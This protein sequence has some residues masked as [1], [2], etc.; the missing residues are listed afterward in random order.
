MRVINDA[1]VQQALL[2]GAPYDVTV[3]VT[4]AGGSAVV[5]DLDHIAENGISINPSGVSGNRLEIGSVIAATG[6][7][8]FFNHDG[9][10]DGIVFKGADISVQGSMDI[11]GVTK[12]FDIGHFVADKA[13]VDGVRIRV[14]CFDYMIKFDT[15]IPDAY[16]TTAATAGQLATACCVF[17][18]VTNAR[19]FS[20]AADIPNYDYPIPKNTVPRGQTYRQVLAWLA[21]I[22]G[23][24]A[25]ITNEGKLDLVWYNTASYAAGLDERF[26]GGTVAE[27]PVTLTGVR[28]INGGTPGVFAGSDGYM[29]DVADN[30]LLKDY[31]QSVVDAIWADVGAFSYYPAEFGLVHNVMATP[32]DVINW[33][34]ED[35]TTKPVAV[36]DVIYNLSA[37]TQIQ[38]K[39]LS[40]DEAGYAPQ[41]AFTPEQETQVKDAGR[42]KIGRIE[43][44]D[45]NVYFDLDSGEISTETSEERV[46]SSTVKAT[47]KALLSFKDGDLSLQIQK[48]GTDIGNT[49]IGIDGIYVRTDE[50]LAPSYPKPQNWDTWPLSTKKI[51]IFAQKVVA[52]LN[53]NNI[54]NNSLLIENKAPPAN[55]SQRINITSQLIQISNLAGDT[56]GASGDRTEQTPNGFFVKKVILDPSQYDPDQGDD[57]EWDETASEYAYDHA[58]VRGTIA[59]ETG[60]KIG[61]ADYDDPAAVPVAT[62]QYVQN[63][64]AGLL[65]DYVE[66]VYTEN[67]WLVYKW[68]SGK[69]EC[70]REANLSVSANSLTQTGAI[71]SIDQT[72]SFPSS[73]FTARPQLYVST[74]RPGSGSSLFWTGANSAST[75]STA[76]YTLFRPEQQ[77]V[78]ANYY[79]NLYAVGTWQ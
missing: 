37:K 72:R 78:A 21:Q 57:P 34:E 47:Y 61:S 13:T 63:Y 44:V 1:A 7:F 60:I 15:L 10:L 14:E 27:N 75:S 18:G 69:A 3:T 9:S 66:S 53:G 46:L 28:Q 16:L 35:G 50:T 19:D 23:R 39:G 12:T 76:H 22:M 29:L 67:D 32:F 45:G 73:L 48:N 64:I 79:V 51:Y 5:V 40:D 36:T 56:T 20:S 43:S 25:V 33:T 6:D 49:N 58:F 70:W 2:D 8:T 11:G 42:L 38:S 26:E 41:S 77:S 59:A 71:Y 4:P 55:H 30:P 52:L 17:C 65:G 54:V 74:S 68:H 24:C 31:A 62:E